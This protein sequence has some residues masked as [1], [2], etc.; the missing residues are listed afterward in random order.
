M[1]DEISVVILTFP[2]HMILLLA[3]K[4]VHSGLSL[5][6]LRFLNWL[7]LYNLDFFNFTFG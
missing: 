6:S 5:I 7:A 4:E 3:F 1:V 2:E